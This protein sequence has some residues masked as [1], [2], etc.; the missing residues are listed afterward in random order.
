[1]TPG[2]DRA[3]V[4]EQRGLC[5]SSKSIWGPVSNPMGICAL[6]LGRVGPL[7]GHLLQS[8][9]DVCFV[10]LIY[11][12]IYLFI[13]LPKWLTTE[14]PKKKKKKGKTKVESEEPLR[15]EKGQKGLDRTCWKAE[16]CFLPP[17]LPGSP[18]C[19]MLPCLA[20]DG[21]F[22]VLPLSLCPD[23]GTPTGEEPSRFSADPSPGGSDLPGR[24]ASTQRGPPGLPPEGFLGAQR[25]LQ[26]LLLGGVVPGTRAGYEAWLCDPVRVT[27]TLNLSLLMFYNEGCSGPAP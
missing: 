21:V 1:M 15:L 3:L 14:R 12:F 17:P 19:P 25:V 11:L 10:G 8:F 6:T 27:Q 22:S 5:L 20:E 13:Y 16:G 7:R 23:L 26:S 24:P 18:L 4:G 2:E 9:P